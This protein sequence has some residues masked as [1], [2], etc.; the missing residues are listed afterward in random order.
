MQVQAT[1]AGPGAPEWKAES[2]AGNYRVAMGLIP[3][4]FEGVIPLVTSNPFSLVVEE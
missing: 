1:L 4:G 3:V 2:V